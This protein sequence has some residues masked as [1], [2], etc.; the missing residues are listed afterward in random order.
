[1][2]MRNNDLSKLCTMVSFAFKA[3][4]NA[5]L[6]NTEIIVLMGIGSVK[7]GGFE[8]ISKACG[9]SESVLKAG[10]GAPA[11][12][13]KKGLIELSKKKHVGTYINIYRPT[14]EGWNVIH[15]MFTGKVREVVK[16]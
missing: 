7:E 6:T 10:T 1:M 14:E 9:S 16:S 8:A 3:G 12:L 5:T 11:A 13:R 2:A 15:A 4:K